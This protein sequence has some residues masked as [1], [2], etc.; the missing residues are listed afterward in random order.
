M[1]RSLLLTIVSTLSIF[2]LTANAGIVYSF[3]HI[4]EEGDG[5]IEFANGAI[6]EAQLFVEVSKLSA[7]KCFSISP[8][9]GHTPARLRTFT[10]T[11]GH[12]WVSHLSTTPAPAFRSLNLQLHTIYRADTL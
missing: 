7:T 6:G 10:L 11:M 3:K 12:C 2:C 1:K 4:V 9:Q 8:T 5:P